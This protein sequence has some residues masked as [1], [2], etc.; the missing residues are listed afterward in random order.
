[1]LVVRVRRRESSNKSEVTVVT[2]IN[3]LFES[4]LGAQ[5]FVVGSVCCLFGRR[6]SSLSFTVCECDLSWENAA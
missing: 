6:Y 5:F 2:I 3:E 4:S 1:M